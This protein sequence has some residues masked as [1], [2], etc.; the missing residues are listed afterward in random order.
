V[1]EAIARACGDEAVGKVMRSFARADVPQG[2]T[3]EV[4]FRDA[5]A[6]FGCDLE[7]VG[8][9]W[10]ALLAETAA[11]ERAR[12]DAIPRM[13]GGVVSRT[14]DSLVVEGTLDRA[15]LP[16]EQY[17]LRFRTDERTPD[18]QVRSVP[19]VV[20]E[21]SAPRR[22]RFTIPRRGVSGPRFEILFSI[23]VDERAFPFSELWQGASTT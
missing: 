16:D 18:T 3:G 8:T 19:G 21:G 17:T 11:T 5:L 15:P 10:D 7:S 4:L 23:S 2:A 6:S 9:A 13:S 12:I 1:G 20:I 22:V 14:S